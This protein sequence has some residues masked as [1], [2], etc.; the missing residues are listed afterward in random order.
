MPATRHTR[1][2][3]PPREPRPSTSRPNVHRRR[4]RTFP[5]EESSNSPSRERSPRRTVDPRLIN[6]LNPD[7]GRLTPPRT[8]NPVAQ[9]LNEDTDSVPSLVSD[10]EYE[11]DSSG[12]LPYS[13]NPQE[14]A[15]PLR[16]LDDVLQPEHEFLQERYMP[17]LEGQCSLDDRHQ[18]LIIPIRGNPIQFHRRLTPVEPRLLRRAIPMPGDRE[19]WD[20]TFTETLLFRDGSRFEAMWASLVALRDNTLIE[21]VDRLRIQMARGILIQTVQEEL[22]RQYA[23]TIDAFNATIERLRCARLRARLAAWNLQP[24][25]PEM[26]QIPRYLRSCATCRTQGHLEREC[27]CWHCEVCGALHPVHPVVRNECWANRRM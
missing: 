7:M 8:E 3:S 16:I 14:F 18:P 5:V 1:S 10:R 4:I 17:Y 24:V 21:D 2:A 6:L 19:D 9:T 23:I 22:T 12:S 13:M 15:P 25:T 26:A 11:P 20:V 27:V